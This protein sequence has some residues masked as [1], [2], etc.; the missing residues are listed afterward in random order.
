MGI[1]GV[2]TKWRSPEGL[3]LF[4]FAMLTVNADGHPVM[5]RFHKPEEEKRMVV[6]L[7]T[8]EYDDWLTCSATDAPRFFKQWMG[9]LDSFAAPL[10]QRAPR[11]HSGNVIVPP[12]PKEPEEP[13]LF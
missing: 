7:D 3:E 9:P 12:T 5:Q 4:S 8:K 2:Y 1:A 13:E 11:T 10:P 6:I